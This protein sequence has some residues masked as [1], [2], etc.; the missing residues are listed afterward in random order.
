MRKAIKTFNFNNF[1]EHLV[2][3]LT[4]TT[5]GILRFSINGMVSKTILESKDRIISTFKTNNLKFPYG[6][7]TTSL[8][9]A[10]IKKNGTH[11]DLPITI[12]LLI[13]QGIINNNE[14][15]DYLFCGEL[16]I[17]GNL[18]PIFN[19]IRIIQFC[20]SNNIKNVMLPFGEYTYINDFT[21]INIFMAK[22]IKEIINHF[23]NKQIVKYKSELYENENNYDFSINDI[24]SQKSLIRALIVAIAGNHSIMIKGPVGVGKTLSIK[25]ISS[26]F[27]KLNKEQTF[28]L[29]EIITRIT[30]TNS[31]NSYPLIYYPKNNIKYTELFGTSKSIGMISKSNFGVIAFDEINTFSSSILN[32]LKIFLDY[33]DVFTFDK[34][35]YFNYPVNSTIISTM[36]PCPCGNYGTSAKCYCTIGEISRHNKK[37]DKALMDR[38]QIKIT[39][40][41][42]K[43]DSGNNN[44]NIKEIQEIISKCIKIQMKRYNSSEIRNG[45]ISNNLIQGYISLS[46]NCLKLLKIFSNKYN[47]S[48]R[49]YNNIIKVARTIA[50]IENS[51]LIEEKHI[52]EAIK[53]NAK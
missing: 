40:E 53:Y 49:S 46:D 20:K 25:S 34:K 39:V 19:P 3:I 31:F 7:T 41:N 15:Y 26:I 42:P 52:F 28:I 14:V 23:N 18:I 6:K 13:Q 17:Y 45:T 22:N 27:S 24:I 2:N 32:S 8:F 11:Y 5:K 33:D 50:D 37:I 29:S 9:P 51:Y 36:N 30:N 10:D 48:R 43:F 35:K 38:F 44:Y 47:I 1:D 21:D 16:D 12:S 4:S